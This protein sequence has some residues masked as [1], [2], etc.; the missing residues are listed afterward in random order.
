MNTLGF[1][2]KNARNYTEQ[3]RM[4]DLS[5]LYVD[6]EECLNPGARILDLGCGSG[7]DSKYFLENGYSVIPVDGSAAMCIA[8]S[9]YLH[10]PVRQMLFSELKFK[11]EFDGI[12]ACASLLHVPKTQIRDIMAKV[13]RALK[14]DGVLYASFKYGEEEINIDGRQFSFYNETDLD[15]IS[16]LGLIEYWISEDVRPNKQG[17]KWLNTLWRKIA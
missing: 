10:I 17:E 11:N 8:A 16:D 14:P 1:Y 13:E 3:T 15:W 6:F 2:N 5:E 4:V 9:E 12:W 7:R